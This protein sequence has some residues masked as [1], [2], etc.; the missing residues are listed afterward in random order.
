MKKI[1]FP[2]DFSP[3]AT[4]AFIHALGLAKSVHGELILLHTY[5]LPI[6]D[7][8]FAPQNYQTIFDSLELAN[9]DKFKDEIPKLRKIAEDNKM[10]DIKMSHML[11]DGDLLYNIKEIIKKEKIDFVVMGT[12]GATGWKE[13]FV[14]TNT[15][16]AIVN[17]SVPVL[18]VPEK[19]NYSKIETIGFTTRFREKDKD[20]LKKVI[21]IAKLTNAVVKCLYVETKSTDNTEDTYQQWHEQFKDEPVQF[22]IIPSEEVNQ[23]IEEFIVH[24]NIDVLAMLT[25]KRSFFKWL[26]T[27][28]FTEKMSYHCTIPILALHE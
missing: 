28:S 14:G 27:S 24:Q 6:I 13:T 7:N 20:A 4:N 10:E 11:M 19:S 17:L 26:F 9:F 18:S 8:Q 5:E 25:Y 16:D 12:S 2:T 1:L 22:F 23:T 15:G 21:E 3:V